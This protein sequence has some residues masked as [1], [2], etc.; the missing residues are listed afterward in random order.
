MS[1]FVL[2]TNK[3]PQNPVHPAKA[4]VLL[5]EGKTAVFRQFPSKKPRLLKRIQK[6]S[7]MPLK[8]AGAVNTTR[9][10]LFRTL[11]KTG[12]PVE[13]GSGGLTKFNRTT[14]GLYKTHWLDAACVGTSTP[15]KIFQS[16][17]VR[18]LGYY[19][20]YKEDGNSSP[21]LKTQGFPCRI[22]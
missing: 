6:Q 20:N 18:C 16:A 17:K 11:K 9:W 2:D 22:L 12:L 10:D 13:T 14:M 3:K 19:L 4:R 7:K 1:V 8:D 5:T 21:E 15:E